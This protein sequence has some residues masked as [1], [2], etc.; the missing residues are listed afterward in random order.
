[1]KKEMKF[2]LLWLSFVFITLFWLRYVFMILP[3]NPAFLH[4]AGIEKVSLPLLLSLGFIPLFFTSFVLFLIKTSNQ[5]DNVLSFF[6]RTAK[7]NQVALE[8]SEA[9]SRTLIEMK[10]I[11]YATQFFSSL[12]VIYQGFYDNLQRILKGIIIADNSRLDSKSKQDIWVFSR[13][14]LVQVARD[15]AILEDIRR[16]FKKHNEIVKE[17]VSFKLGYEELVKALEHYDKDSFLKN[18]IKDGS[19]GRVYGLLSKVYERAFPPTKIV[20][21][22]VP[23]YKKEENEEQPSLL[24]GLSISPKK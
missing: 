16:N 12:P 21:A 22:E 9:M 19:L 4:Y 5:S 1:M 6:K 24:S 10:K 18:F 2:Y 17:F 14:F 8:S 13:A 23:I 7:M 11:G 15:P 20:Q 3:S